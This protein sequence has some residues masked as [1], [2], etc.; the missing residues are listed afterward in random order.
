VA[1]GG[2]VRGCRGGRARWG[3][4]N[5]TVYFFYFAGKLFLENLLWI[6]TTFRSRSLAFN[7]YELCLVWLTNYTSGMEN[8]P[9]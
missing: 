6:D 2:S 1:G 3:G 8:H 9:P 4:F 5:D 7:M